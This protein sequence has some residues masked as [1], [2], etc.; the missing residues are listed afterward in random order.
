MGRMTPGRKIRFRVDGYGTGYLV[1]C[2]EDE[3]AGSLVPEAFSVHNSEPVALRSELFAI[4]DTC[5]PRDAPPAKLPVCS[6]EI[7]L[8]DGDIIIID[9]TEALSSHQA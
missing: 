9:S 6:Q 3:V 8:V 5:P 7:A 4:D 2:K 1:V